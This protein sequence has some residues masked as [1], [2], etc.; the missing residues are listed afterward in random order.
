MILEV[1]I[2]N[3]YNVNQFLLDSSQLGIPNNRPRYYLLATNCKNLEF[4]DYGEI[5]KSPEEINLVE[6][7]RIAPSLRKFLKYDKNVEMN[8]SDLYLKTNFLAKES[9][10]SLGIFAII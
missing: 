3:N 10:L 4:N 1:L 8:L 5:I 6:E 9:S 2:S 7:S